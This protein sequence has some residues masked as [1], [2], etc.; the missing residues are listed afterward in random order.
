M[1]PQQ[2]CTWTNIKTV[3]YMVSLAAQVVLIAVQ[4][5]YPR[6]HKVR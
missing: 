4:D 1:K 3:S 2:F 5:S 6:Y